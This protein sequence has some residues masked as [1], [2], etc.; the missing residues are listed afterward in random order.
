MICIY[1]ITAPDGRVYI[2][3]TVNHIERWRMY[4]NGYCYTQRKLFKSLIKHGSDNHIFEILEECTFEDLNE[5][6]KYYIK[7]YDSFYK[8]LNSSYL[9]MD[10]D[11]ISKSKYYSNTKR[12]S[13]LIKE[14]SI[15]IQDKK[16]KKEIVISGDP[17]ERN[18]VVYDSV[19]GIF[20]DNISQAAEAYD[21]KYSSLNAYLYGKRKNRTNLR[22]VGKEFKYTALKRYGVDKGKPTGSQEKGINNMSNKKIESYCLDTGKVIQ[23]FYSMTN[24]DQLGFSIYCV[25]KVLKGIKTEYRGMGFRYSS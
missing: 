5:R 1:K 21:L 11:D 15:E 2:G 14:K 4:K 8:G 12:K 7:F 16:Y 6:E 10:K 25:R 17:L 9:G 18:T 3:Q 23:S 19:T 24:A 20:F 13:L 22:L